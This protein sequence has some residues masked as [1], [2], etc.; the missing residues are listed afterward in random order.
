MFRID[1]EVV[2][3]VIRYVL[4]A[5][6]TF[7]THI[8]QRHRVSRSFRTARNTQ[9]IALRLGIVLEHRVHPV[10]IIHI[11]VRVVDAFERTPV[12]RRIARINRLFVHNH[13]IFLC[14]QHV[15]LTCLGL[16]AIVSIK[17]N[18]RLACLTAL[19]GYQY[20]TVG[21]LCTVDSGRSGIFQ[22]IDAFDIGWIQRG[23]ITAYSINQIQRRSISHRTQT[24][25]TY[26]HRFARL[27]RGRRNVH[28]RRLSLHRLQ[29]AVGIHLRQ[30]LAFHLHRGT[31]HQFLFL[32]AVTYYDYFIQ[33]FRIFFHHHI[34]GFLIGDLNFL[35]LEPDVREYQRL[36]G[37][38]T[39]RIISIEVGNRTIG[40]S[41]HL[42]A[43]ADKRQLVSG[44]SNNTR[45]S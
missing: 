23:D 17:R 38:Y 35:G 24:T 29:G 45:N 5:Y 12:V 26:F 37:S 22:H 18:L 14:V 28:T 42:N 20:H 39:D 8:A 44:R 13:H 33:S 19:G 40:C 15:R 9:S 41:L 27:T 2:T 34:Q 32:N 7:L 4:T 3:F 31:G 36:A 21:S 10:S 43:D 1:T 6:D 16:P 25:D 30:R 11:A